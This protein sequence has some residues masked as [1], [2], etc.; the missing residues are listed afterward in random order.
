[1]LYNRYMGSLGE[2]VKRRLT[3][4][5]LVFDMDDRLSYFNK[6]SLDI[7]SGIKPAKKRGVR[8]PYIPEEIYH[9]CDLLKTNLTDKKRGAVGCSIMEIRSG[10]SCSLR[11]FFLSGH[12][13]DHPTHIMVLIEKI[14]EKREVDF[15]K[16]KRDFHL[17]NRESEVLRFLCQGNTNKGIAEKLF[18]SEYTVKDHMKKIMGKMGAKS[19][20]EIMAVMK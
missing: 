20:S 1:M 7:L 9:L 5:I 16:T 2:I 3:P 18:I 12:G 14:V 10:F 17:S 13:E 4:G 11:A 15:E 8:K 19:R 6:E